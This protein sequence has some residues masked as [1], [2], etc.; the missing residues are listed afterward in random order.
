MSLDLEIRFIKESDAQAALEIYKYY[1]ENT[2]ISFE[3]E[4]PSVDE[5]K[6]RIKTNTEKYPWIV[7]LHKNKIIGFAYGSTHRYR[8][9]Y[10][11]SPESTVYIDPNFHTQRIGRILYETLFDLMKLQGYYN[12]FAGVALPNT[13]SVG[14][15]KAL[16]FEEIGLFKKVGFKHGNWHDT[17]W[18]QLNLNEENNHP[19][20]PTYLEDLITSVE[21]SAIISAANNKLARR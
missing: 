14:L 20:N 19:N 18:F 4:A 5:Y 1:V 2:F 6:A 8:T 9:A 3:Y 16:G 17:L 15:H 13:K 7:C 11:W 21:V 12:V 10:Q